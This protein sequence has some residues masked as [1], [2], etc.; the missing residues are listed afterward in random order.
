MDMRETLALF[1][2]HFKNLKKHECIL[3]TNFDSDLRKS[4]FLPKHRKKLVFLQLSK[5][6]SW[7]RV[8]W[9]LKEDYLLLRRGREYRNPNPHS[10]DEVSQNH[11]PVDL[12]FEQIISPH[13]TPSTFTLSYSATLQLEWLLSLVQDKHYS[14]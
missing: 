3:K 7:Q 13:K 8:L 5:N 1:N 2:E 12:K 11:E 14:K 9:C 4:F 6:F 10:Q